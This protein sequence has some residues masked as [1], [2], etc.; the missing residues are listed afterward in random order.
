MVDAGAP[1]AIATSGSSQ[2][3]GGLPSTGSQRGST[4]SSAA[5][6][7]GSQRSSGAQ[8]G[9][10]R[11]SSSSNNGGAAATGSQRSINSTQALEKL[12]LLEEMLARER[13]AREEAEGTL[14][15]L[16]KERQA[17]DLALR[18]SQSAHRQLND[19]MSALQKILVDPQDTSA[20]R[21]LQAVVRGS[22]QAVATMSQPSATRHAVGPS[23]SDVEPTPAG[24]T[25]SFLDGIGQY[26]RD[27]KLQRRL[28]GHS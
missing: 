5:A 2:R 9:G 13:Q 19:V 25:G 23:S 4:R 7:A 26:E 16:Q 15:A 1:V 17:K 10:S 12:Q 27:R 6:A 11:R 3:S 21:R 20:I 28:P 22:P 14:L 8:S 18:Q 24:G